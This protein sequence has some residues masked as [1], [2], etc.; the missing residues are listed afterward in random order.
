MEAA[1]TSASIPSGAT[2]VSAAAASCCMIISTTA[3]KVSTYST[4]PTTAETQ[5]TFSMLVE[6]EPPHQMCR[7]RGNDVTPSVTQP[8]LFPSHVH[9]CRLLCVPAGCDHVLNS[10]SGTISSPNWPDRYPSKK[11][12]TWALSTTP[13]HR[14]KLVRP[15]FL[16]LSTHFFFIS[17]KYQ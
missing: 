15:C 1:S 2:V 6:R 16:T 5:V 17:F 14:V 10:V 12:C 3:R 7:S 13:G 9:H 4:G 8:S 11:A